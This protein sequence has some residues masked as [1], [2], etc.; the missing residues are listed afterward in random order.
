MS[1]AIISIVAGYIRLNDRAA[2]E[3]LRAHRQRLRKQLQAQWT[4]VFD[5]SSSIQLFDEDLHVIEAAL[6]SF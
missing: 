2:L 6:A 3:E 1:E 4:D 5:V